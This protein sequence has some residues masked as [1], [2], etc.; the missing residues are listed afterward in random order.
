M[1]EYKEFRVTL[2]KEFHKYY[3]DQRQLMLRIA[4]ICAI[5]MAILLLAGAYF[6]ALPKFSVPEMIV[7]GGIWFLMAL[8]SFSAGAL[9]AFEAVGSQISRLIKA[10]EEK[11]E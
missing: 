3:W 7:F 8:V 9:S 6:N 1:K 4:L 5:G 10:E 11:K 2:T